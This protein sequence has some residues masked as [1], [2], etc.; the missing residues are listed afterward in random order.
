[1]ADWLVV[2]NNSLKSDS[3]AGDVLS[4]DRFVQGKALDHINIKKF[5]C[6]A[7]HI[8]ALSGRSDLI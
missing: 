6:G 7:A 1:M 2:S 4:H 8:L 5:A 3:I